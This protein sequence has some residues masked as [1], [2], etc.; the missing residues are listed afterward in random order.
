VRALLLIA[1]MRVSSTLRLLDSIT[2]V[3]GILGRPSEP[4][5]GRR[6]APARWRAMTPES[7]VVI[8]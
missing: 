1:V 7:V 6:A 4:V 5:I 8:L 2:A 3:S